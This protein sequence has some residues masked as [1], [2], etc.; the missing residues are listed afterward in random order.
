MTWYTL[1][2]P[3]N[4]WN[5]NDDIATT[6]RGLSAIS[7]E[8]TSTDVEGELLYGSDGEQLFGSGGEELR[9]S[10]E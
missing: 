9:G 2:P 5:E 1:P 8:W 7:T 4:G 6:W 3:S 10:D